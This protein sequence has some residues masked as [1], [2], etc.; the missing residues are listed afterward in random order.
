MEKIMSIVKFEINL[1]EAVTTIKKFKE[2]R[3]KAL[4]ELAEDVRS[5]VSGVVNELLNAEMGIYLGEPD[6]ANNKRNG[7]KERRYAIKGI[8]AISIKY[9][10]ARK[11]GFESA[12][13]PKG[14]RIDPRIKEDMAVLEL[15]GLSTRTMSMMSKRLL[16]IE[17]SNKTVAQSLDLISDRAL[18]WL[19][20]P[21]TEHYWALYID[22]TNFNIQRRGSTQK[23]P[24]LVVLGIDENDYRSVLAIEPGYKDSADAWRTVLKGLKERG[25]D[26]LS[27]RIGIMDGLPG[28]ERV[29][30]E[31]FPKAVTARCWVHAMK[32]ALNKI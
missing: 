31:E 6:Q 26:P 1:S 2:N 19:T 25:L 29:F 3:L 16:G 10:Q 23:E 7:H 32:N 20:R 9:P 28:L 13:I 24:S 11:A 21:I 12:I 27:V 15:A 22:G 8:G 14:E 18:S 17:V 4:E 5:S 30:A